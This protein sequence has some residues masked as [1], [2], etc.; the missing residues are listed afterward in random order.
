MNK[1]KERL[2]MRATVLKENKC[3]LSLPANQVV[4]IKSSGNIKKKKNKLTFPC[5]GLLDSELLVYLTSST[6]SSLAL[7]RTAIKGAFAFEEPNYNYIQTK[8]KIF[9]L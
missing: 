2:Q 5:T 3:L 8:I 9:S 7:N 4:P 1:K 6:L